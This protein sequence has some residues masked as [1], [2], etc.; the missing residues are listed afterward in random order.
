MYLIEAIIKAVLN[1]KKNK[2]AN[3]IQTEDEV[4]Y[5]NHTFLPLDSSTEY[6]AC[7]KCGVVI[8][9]PKLKK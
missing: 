9:N 4:E 3:D 5:C 7:S 1:L 8:K 6:L 2:K